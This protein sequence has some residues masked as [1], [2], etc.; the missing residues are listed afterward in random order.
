MTT[1]VVVT[2]PGYP[3]KKVV[4]M[5]NNGKSGPWQRVA[6]LEQGQ[7]YTSVAH[8]SQAVCV[9]ELTDAEYDEAY[10]EG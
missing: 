4:V 9:Q 5:V 6:V 7:T 1:N 2:A 3:G 10:P 8:D